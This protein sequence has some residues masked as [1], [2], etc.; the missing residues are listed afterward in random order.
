RVIKC[1]IS[2]VLSRTDC[3]SVKQVFPYNNPAET[4]QY[5]SLPFCRSS[6]GQRDG[7]RERQRFGELLVGDRKVGFAYVFFFFCFAFLLR[8]RV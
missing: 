7:Q 4:Y 2:Y 8:S 3:V 6:D 1:S 5:Y